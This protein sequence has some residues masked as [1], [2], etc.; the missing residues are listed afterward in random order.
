M[1]IKKVEKELFNSE[2]VKNVRQILKKDERNDLAEIKKWE[3]NTVRVQEKGF[4]LVVLD[5]D[6]YVHRVEDQIG[7]SYFL[8]LDHNPTQKLD[9]KIEKWLEGW[10]KIYLLMT[11]RSHILNL[12]MLA[13]LVKCTVQ[14][15]HKSLV[16]QLG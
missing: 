3:N 8:Q 1:S 5:N 9:F 12:L 10:T 13:Y 4:R 16:I 7:R 11:N 2:N 14:S 6:H 15:K